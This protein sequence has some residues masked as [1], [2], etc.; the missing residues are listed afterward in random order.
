MRFRCSRLL[1]IP[2][3]HLIDREQLEE[4]TGFKLEKAPEMAQTDPAFAMNK[5]TPAKTPLQTHEN[6]LQNVAKN[7][8]GQGEGSGENALVEAL[9]SLFEKTLA[10]TMAEELE[11]EGKGEGEEVKNTECRAQDPSQCHTHG[12]RA[13]KS[14]PEGDAQAKKCGYASVQ[15]MMDH[16]KVVPES[17][18][19]DISKGYSG[20]CEAHEAIAVISKNT[21]FYDSEGNS[22]KFSNDI[23]E[24]YIEGRRRRDNMPKISNLEDLPFAIKAVKSDTYGVTRL[25]YPKGTTPDPLNPPRGTQREYHISANGGQMKV[26]VYIQGGII[27]GWHVAK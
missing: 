1:R 17:R 3:L 18:I 27:N 11:N 19:E 22:V 9:N 5:A 16:A 4:K 2:S 20:K 26:F 15:D 10:E 14:S 12:V 8:D 24:H 6:R 7:L 23:L 21:P 25:K 13:V